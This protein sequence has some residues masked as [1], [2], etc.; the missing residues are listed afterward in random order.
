[1]SRERTKLLRAYGA[2]VHETPSLGGMGEAI[3]LAERIVA[4]RGAFMPQQFANPANPEIHRRTT[5]EEIWRDT[6]GEVDALVTGVGTGGT[7]TGVGGVLKERRPD[8]RV[9]AVEPAGSPVLSGGAPGPHKIQGIGAG[10]VPGVLDRDVIDEIIV[11]SDEDALAAARLAASREGMLVGISAG[12]AFHAALEVAA[13]PE[14]AGKRIVTIACDGG[15]RYMSLP[16]FQEVAEMFG[17][18]TLGTFVKEVTSDVAAARDRDPAARGVGTVEI[19]SGWAGVQ[20]LLAHRVAHALY[21][22]GVPV[23]PR[24]IAFT[25]RAVTGIEIH[26][27]ARIGR[28]FFIDHGAGVVIGETAEIGERVTLYQ[29]VTLGGTGFAR[30]KRHP[31]VED[32]VTIGSG[33]KLLGPVTVGH[34]A[35]IGANTVVIEDVPPNSTVVGNPGHPVRVEGRRPE[36]PDADWIHL[37]D[38][39]AD[40]LKAISERLAALE[41]RLEGARRQ[42]GC[43]RGQGAAAEAGPELGRRLNPAPAGAGA[44]RARDYPRP[45]MDEA[46]QQLEREYEQ[47]SLGAPIQAGADHVER[48]LAELN[49]PQ[50]EAVIHGD[51]PLLVLA[52]AGSGKTR[53]LT[54]RIAWLLATGRAR[55]TE[56]LAITFTNKAAGEMRERVSQLVGGVSRA[57]WVTTFHSACARILRADAQR[58]G[59]KRAFTIYDE[60]DSLRMIK[61]CMEENEL[62]PK[63]YPPRAIKAAISAAKN[64][65]TDSI[66]YGEASVVEL[67]GGG[68]RHLPPLRAADGR[69]ERDGLR[70]PPRPHRQPARALPRR[71]REVPPDLPPRAGRRVPGHEPGAV[72][73]ARS[74]SPRSTGI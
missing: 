34:G 73:A 27:A 41:K 60:A 10:F 3:A 8:F 20:A 32:D 70:R 24:T 28:D 25:S 11:V 35:K 62:D 19:L 23:A 45:F 51:G 42:G 66:E 15:E 9:I 44:R 52:G 56:I 48:L 26:P 57:M 38:P 65:L 43:G 40:A 6:G 13:R 61:R 33:A 7:I 54:Y 68:R 1:M 47:E 55:P 53:V 4:D 49:D 21:D 67:R 69:G 50:R 58:L 46:E 18:G 16:F 22:A 36:G 29:G 72:P 37:P 30:G 63:R 71:P 17:L 31:T 39:I 12:A 74:C 2:E 14:M 5:A 64:Q 59:Y